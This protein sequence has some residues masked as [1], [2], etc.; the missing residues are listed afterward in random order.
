MFSDLLPDY[1]NMWPL[2]WFDQHPDG[3]VAV[4]CRAC[5]VHVRLYALQWN[6]ATG[7]MDSL[8]DETDEMLKYHYRYF[9][10][11][12]N[13]D[14]MLKFVDSIT[15]GCYADCGAEAVILFWHVR[16][17]DRFTPS[18]INTFPSS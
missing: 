17:I 4:V 10:G 6:D 15:A 2:V 7:V 12:G 14:N 13:V 8:I 9:P 16:G 1:V 5:A 11:H 3:A 18:N